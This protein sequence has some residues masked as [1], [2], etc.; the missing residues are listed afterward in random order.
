MQQSFAL[1]QGNY[2]NVSAN[3]QL[4]FLFKG[5]KPSSFDEIPQEWLTNPA[6]MIKNSIGMIEI[7]STNEVDNENLIFN[8]TNLNSYVRAQGNAW[9]EDL[10]RWCIQSTPLVKRTYQGVDKF[11]DNEAPALMGANQPQVYEQFYKYNNDIVLKDSLNVSVYDYHETRRITNLPQHDSQL[12]RSV[13]NYPLVFELGTEQTLDGLFILQAAA[14]WASDWV[15][16]SAWDDVAEEWLPSFR[17]PLQD[18][19]DPSITNFPAI[20]T[21]RILAV[22]NDTYSSSWHPRY[23]QW[24]STVEP[25]DKKEA[26]DITWGLVPWIGANQRTDF[27]A[28]PLLNFA[29]FEN[30]AIYNQVQGYPFLLVDVGS[31]GDNTTVILNN[32]TDVLPHDDISVLHM[33]INFKDVT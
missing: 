30:E 33:G 29:E 2:I 13:Q 11:G 8:Y 4:L 15:D 20:T 18:N 5:V 32:A 21:K 23:W 7:Q 6:E 12:G 22:F 28:Y 10:Q 14:N 9:S 26:Y 19:P 25:V 24:V 3:K 16:V 31:P 17:V 1:R 27:H